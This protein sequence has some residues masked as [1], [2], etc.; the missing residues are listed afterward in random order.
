LEVATGGEETALWEDE[1]DVR[2]NGNV[3]FSNMWIKSGTR[4]FEES[5]GKRRGNWSKKK[6]CCKEKFSQLGA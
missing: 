5:D 2:E 4:W 1:R 3:H 6:Y